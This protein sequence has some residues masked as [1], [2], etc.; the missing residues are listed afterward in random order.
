M[1]H[2][3][4]EHAFIKYKPEENWRKMLSR[5]FRKKQRAV[6]ISD[7]PSH[8]KS[9][10]Y[11]THN[12]PRPPR[13]KLKLFLLAIILL[14]WISSLAYTSYFKITKIDYFGLENLSRSE[15][16]N[17]IYPKYLSRTEWLPTNNYFFINTKKLETD[18]VDVFSL[19]HATVTK[20]FPHKL[21]IDI[22][23]K[24]PALI[25]D[26]GKKYFLLD[27]EGTAVKYLADVGQDELKTVAG[28]PSVPLLTNTSTPATTSPL[29]F[30]STIEHTPNYQKI[31]RLF[32]QY[33]I[34][35]DRRNLEITE[36]QTGLLSPEYI[37]T[38]T[39]WHKELSEQGSAKPKFFVF[40]NLNSGMII[41]TTQSWDII[42]QPKNSTE[43]QINILRGILSTIKPKAYIDLRF[44]EKVYWK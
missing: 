17:F 11:R 30:A 31:T 43:E 15:M 32:G 44:G 9:N 26:N 13:T 37:T 25:Y 2:F 23:E 22:K 27:I 34:V 3:R 7:L 4:S 16:D 33:P 12:Q 42:F 1:K 41:D 28:L 29:E 20:H 35:Y 38:I 18:L 24:T 6:P 8:Y 21:I 19:E 14:G 39:T 36:K 40:D 5:I 10:P